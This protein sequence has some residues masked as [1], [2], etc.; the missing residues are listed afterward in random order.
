M[1]S[2]INLIRVFVIKALLIVCI[3]CSKSSIA[4]QEYKRPKKN[5][6]PWINLDNHY[7]DEANT[8]LKTKDSNYAIALSIYNEKGVYDIKIIKIDEYGDL[9]WHKT[10]GGNKSDYAKSMIEDSNGNFIIIGSTE[11]K[12][13]EWREA[14]LLKTDKNGNLLWDKT[15]E[16]KAT[17]YANS[18]I[19]SKDGNYIIAGSTYSK[20]NGL[21]DAWLLKTDKDG[22]LL[23]DKTFGGSNQDK[24]ISIIES[25]DGGYILAGETTSKGN[26]L[27][28]AW[29]LK[30]DK[31]WKPIMG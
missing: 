27:Q 12:E 16:S 26:G 8:I 17:N 2:N 31:K 6:Q 21:Q 13:N 22:A 5:N 18:V 30:T 19:E 11:S 4:S 29:L 7:L 14:W 9:I 24:A 1:K 3:L 25:I 28:D 10:F 23:W 20:G 15:F